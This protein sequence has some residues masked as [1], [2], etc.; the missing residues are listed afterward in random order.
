MGVCE[1][2]LGIYNDRL[3]SQHKAQMKSAEVCH[4]NFPSILQH[5]V[6]WATFKM[7]TTFLFFL[8]LL[9]TAR[10][11]ITSLWCPENISI[12]LWWPVWT[13]WSF[14]LLRPPLFKIRHPVLPKGW[15][16]ANLH[17]ELLV[18]SIMDSWMCLHHTCLWC[19]FLFSPSSKQCS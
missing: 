4:V 1:M 7:A 18:W 6:I 8:L 14:S 10:P 2:H 17:N 9:L 12:G 11:S 3:Y 19:I 15:P 13:L 16:K 5:T